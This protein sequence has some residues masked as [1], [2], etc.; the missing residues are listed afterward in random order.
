MWARMSVLS[1]V[2]EGG[3]SA[4]VSS[5]VQLMRCF[6]FFGLGMMLCWI[7]IVLYGERA[8]GGLGSLLLVVLRYRFCLRVK[9]DIAAIER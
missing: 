7:R 9:N 8:D 1:D 4:A 6:L 2:K 5:F 3:A